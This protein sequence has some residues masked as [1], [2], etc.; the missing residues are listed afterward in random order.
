MI[1]HVWSMTFTD[2]TTDEQRAS[3][4]AAMAELPSKIEGVASF[5]SGTDLGLNRGNAD[6]G[7]VAEFADADAWSAYIKHPAHV[8]FV[9]DH[10]TPLCASWGAFQ[11]AS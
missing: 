11:I 7:I 3:F 8:A 4:I 9:D 10:V 5:R 6:V 1:T 2:E